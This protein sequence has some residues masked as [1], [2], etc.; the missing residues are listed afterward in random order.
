MSYLTFGKD[1]LEAI[2]FRAGEETDS[3]SDYFAQ[4]K[5]YVI[6]AIADVHKAAP[7]PFALKDPPG[8]ISLVAKVTGT[9]NSIAGTTWTLAATI[10][11]SQA[12]KKIIL[13]SEQ[14]P[15]RITAHTAGTAVVTVDATYAETVTAGAFTI[16]QDEYALATDSLRP[17]YGWFRNRPN[18]T[19]DFISGQEGNFMWPSRMRYTVKSTYT[20]SIVH[21]NKV[22]IIPWTEEA[23]TIEYQYSFRPTALDFTGAGAGDTPAIP[24]DD[25]WVAADRALYYLSLD[26]KDPRADAYFLSSEDGIENMVMKL[27]GQQK[28]RFIPRRGSGLGVR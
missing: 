28:P 4:S 6:R 11:T 26:K 14:I 24:Q 20:A 19:I 21:G 25:L 23:A 8:I 16:F 9:V 18:E 15:Y 12:G 7:F 13:D 5:K 1:I 10:A 3:N 27:I 22:R 2:L 17:W